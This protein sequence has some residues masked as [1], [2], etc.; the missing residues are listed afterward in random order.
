MEDNNENKPIMEL[1][2]KD[3][4]LKLQIS[5]YYRDELRNALLNIKSLFNIDFQDYP[6]DWD[7][8]ND[9]HMADYL[10][11]TIKYLLINKLV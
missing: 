4:V 10:Y 11:E 9:E 8:N 3:I 2:K 5:E 1:D 7:L 6:M